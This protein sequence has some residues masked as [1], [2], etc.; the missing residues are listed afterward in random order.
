MVDAN[1]KF[2]AIDVGSFEKEGNSGIFLKSNM[3]QHVLNGSFGFPNLIINFP[4]QI[5]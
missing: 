4:N 3:G 2:V 5:R 1:H